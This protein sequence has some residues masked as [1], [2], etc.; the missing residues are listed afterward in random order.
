MGE[1]AAERKKE[2][3]KSKRLLKVQKS[4]REQ[5][6]LEAERE[7]ETFWMPGEIRKICK[8]RN[9]SPARSNT[10]AELSA[11]AWDGRPLLLDNVHIIFIWCEG[12]I[13]QNDFLT[14]IYFCLLR[15][16]SANHNSPEE[17][18]NSH[19]WKQNIPQTRNRPAH[20]WARLQKVC[21]RRQ[22]R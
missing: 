13:N 4:L 14:P 12:G 10:E 19:Q 15:I 11:W 5:R 9:S 6:G 21:D 16:C 2:N 7:R 20:I 18:K 8:E 3:K 22:Q 1:E 17:E